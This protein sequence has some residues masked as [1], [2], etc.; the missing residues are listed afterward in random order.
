[1]GEQMY[2]DNQKFWLVNHRLTHFARLFVTDGDIQLTPDTM[3]ELASQSEDI[4]TK[5]INAYSGSDEFEEGHDDRI[6]GVQKHLEDQIGSPYDKL[7]ISDVKTISDKFAKC[8][9][10]GKPKFYSTV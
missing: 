10:G 6:K 3:R 5:I 1:V 9:S 4:L 2:V 8:L 7:E